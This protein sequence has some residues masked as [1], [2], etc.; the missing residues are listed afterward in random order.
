M[1]SIFPILILNARPAAGKSEIIQYLESVPLHE[2]LQRFHIGPINSLDDFPMLWAWFEEDDLLENVFGRSRLHSTSGRYF[3]D[4]VY[5]NLLIE[6]LNLEYAKWVKDAPEG[7]T[8]I[9]EFS[10]GIEHGGYNA[11]YEH[12]S[13]QIL[14]NGATLYVNVSFE[15]SL[16]KNRARSNPDRPDSILEHSLEDEK[17]IRLYREDDWATLTSSNPNFVTIRNH[18][19]PFI[20]FENEDDVTSQGGEELGDQLSE[21]FDR[22]WSLYQK[23]G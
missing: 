12:L 13:D 5:W 23:N 8:C 9:I 18:Q 16:R 20:V 10:R 1:A 7:H 11:A 21:A 4:R 19:I 6:R 2:R 15:E 17:M 22:L 14:S 3:L